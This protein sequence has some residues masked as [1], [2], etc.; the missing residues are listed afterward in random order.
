MHLIL[1]TACSLGTIIIPISDIRKLTCKVKN[2]NTIGTSNV[3]FQIYFQKKKKKWKQGFKLILVYHV[4][5]SII[6][7]SQKGKTTQTAISR[8]MDKHN[9]VYPY[10]GILCSLKKEWH[11]DVSYNMDEMWRHDAKWNKADTEEQI[12]YDSIY[13]RYRQES[14]SQRYKVE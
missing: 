6:H 2:R 8:W 13:M 4:Q 12:L 11:S 5:S 3:H 14:N 1:T 7:H 9:V 10:S